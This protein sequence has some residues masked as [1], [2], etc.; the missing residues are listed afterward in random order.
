MLRK[1]YSCFIKSKNISSFFTATH[2]SPIHNEQKFLFQQRLALPWKGA[3]QDDFNHT[4]QTKCQV[5]LQTRIKTQFVIIIE[6]RVVI[7]SF[8]I[9]TTT[10]KFCLYCKL[11]K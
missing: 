1:F 5:P 7:S 2:N 8:L 3:H 10:T 6:W 9:V 4:P 11:K